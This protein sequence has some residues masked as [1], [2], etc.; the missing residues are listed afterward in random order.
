[1]RIKRESHEVT[2]EV[3]SY[4][5]LA[6]PCQARVFFSCPRR[7]SSTDLKRWVSWHSVSWHS[8]LAFRLGDGFD[9]SIPGQDAGREFWLCDVPSYKKGTHTVALHLADMGNKIAGIRAA[10]ML[11]DFPSIG[12]VFMTGI[13]GGVPHPEK[14]EGYVADWSSRAMLL[15]RPSQNLPVHLSS[16]LARLARFS[17]KQ[18]M[19]HEM[20]RNLLRSK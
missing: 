5:T 8:V 18:R 2:I 12:V 17:F 14:A 6:N 19:N 3:D 7:L 16:A 15:K 11:E 10:K 4:A 1:M 13:A 9:L 20:E